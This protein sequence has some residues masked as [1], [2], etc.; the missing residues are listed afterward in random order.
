M[1]APPA[2]SSAETASEM[3]EVYWQALT[4]EIPFAEYATHTLI[5]A[6]AEDLSR[7]SEFRGSKVNGVVTSA[8]LFRGPTS[9]DLVGPYLSQFLWLDVDHGSMT[10]TQR[11]RVPIAHDDYMRTYPEWLNIQRG[12]PPTRVNVLDPTPRYLRN[13]HDVGEYVHR[14]FIYQA[15]LNACVILLA[16]NAPLKANNPYRRSLTQSGFITFDSE[17]GWSFPYALQ[18][19]CADGGRGTQ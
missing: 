11:N 5:T 7:C 9:G 3:V 14:D 6:A 2:F 17:P 18:G 8:T 19:A 1:P 16:M 4:R 12:L 15:Y 10:L 13:R